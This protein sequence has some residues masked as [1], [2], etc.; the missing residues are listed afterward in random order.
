MS[1]RT[2]KLPYKCNSEEDYQE[3]LRYIKNYNCVLRY[4]YNRYKENQFSMSIGDLTKLQ[5]QMNNVFLNSWLLAS[6]QTEVRQMK[7]KEHVIF[8]GKKLFLDRCKGKISKEDFQ[9]KRLCPLFSVG[10]ALSSGNRTFQIINVNTI[11]FHHDRKHNITLKLPNLRKSYLRDL[12]T[13]VQLQQDKAIPI[14]YKLGLKFIYISFDD[15][16]VVEYQSKF[17]PS[18]KVEHRVFSIDLNPNYIGWSVVDWSSSEDYHVVDS[19]VVSCKKL[20]DLQNDL[21]ES[22]D[23][24][25]NV[26][27]NN[28]KEFENT[29]TA[30]M[31]AKLANHYGCSIF[32]LE[33]LE[34]ETKDT[35]SG[36]RYN[37]L[38]NNH[39]NRNIF[40]NQIKKYCD[41][42]DIRY[43]EVAAN[44]SSFVG[45]FVY[46]ETGLPDMVLASIEIGRR[47][48]EYYHQYISKDK[49]VT[50]N[51]I[52]DTS[53]KAKE[54]IIKSL[55]E[56]DYF[57]AFEDIKSLYYT[58]KTLKW[59]Y[60]VPLEDSILQKVSS[61]KSIKSQ[62]LLYS[63]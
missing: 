34:I 46:R 39:W 17:Q 47:A 5:K 14:T 61:K 55:E 4:T 28:K 8:G 31:L 40:Y 19:G 58:L 52:F 18:V 50:K 41:R 23:S 42:Y 30:I 38:V 2:I 3:I 33:K 27:L 26:Y 32:S 1:V 15:K 9:M 59:N 51:I 37:R 45:N 63:S 20:N 22:S 21:H 13:L 29:D 7:Y 44:Y 48:Y 53:E 49:P 25:N 16:K 60:R 6:A 10:E 11:N 36:K 54:R 56:F 35:G 62:I 12:E 24:K 43:Q 57:E